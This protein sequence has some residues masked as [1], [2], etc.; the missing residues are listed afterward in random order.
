MT[1]DVCATA[2][3]PVWGEAA[4]QLG[5]HLVEES[6]DET[7]WSR[8]LRCPT[9]AMQ[10]LEDCPFSELQGGGPTR[11]RPLPLA[12]VCACR[13]TAW[14]AGDEAAA[15]EREHLVW[16]RHLGDDVNLWVCSEGLAV[17]DDEAPAGNRLLSR[18][19]LTDGA[20]LHPL[21]AF[22]ASRG[23]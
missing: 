19:W 10:W 3:P 21:L 22:S 16:V 1:G 9:T 17:W 4:R 13:S 5:E 18:I 14:F 11:L 8:V 6:R 20:P 7:G 12:S 15:Y 23:W 2:V